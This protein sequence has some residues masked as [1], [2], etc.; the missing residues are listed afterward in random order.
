AHSAPGLLLTD[1]SRLYFTDVVSGHI[2]PLVVPVSGGEPAPVSALLQV[3]RLLD[4]SHDGNELLAAG[5]KGLE[6]P[7]WVVPL[8]GGVPRRVGDFL[9][10]DANWS[11]DSHQI[12]YVN[13]I[14]IFVATSDGSQS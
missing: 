2:T 3:R 7:L 8:V 13:G 12:A 14:D 4:I 1:G 5:A 9:T 6:S 10:H 11:P